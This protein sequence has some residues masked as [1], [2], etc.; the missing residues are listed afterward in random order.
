MPATNV[1][2]QIARAR[3]IVV[4]IGTS[5]ITG[6]DGR[7]DGQVISDLAAQIAA[8]VQAGRSVTL[9]ASGAIGAGMAE[10]DLPQRPKRLP[11]LQATAAVGQGQ[12]MREFHDVFARHGLKVAQVLVTRDAFE[13]RGRY[14]N[15]RQTL[16]AL[17][18]LGVLAIINE[19]DAVAVDEIRFG[20]NDIIAAHVANLI[21]ANLL[22]LLTDVDGVLDGTGVRDVI[23]QVDERAMSLATRGRSR[24]GSGGMV[25]KIAA[26][27]MVTSAGEIAVIANSRQPKVLA[28]LLSGQNVGTAFVPARRRM[29][30]RRRWIAQAARAAGK[31]MIDDGACAAIRQR[32]KSLL[33]SG[34][35]G[36]MGRFA[37]G[38][39]VEVIDRAGNTVARGLCNY[40][41]D[42]IDKIKGMKT[43]QVVGILGPKARDEVVHRNNLTLA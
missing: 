11:M 37:R 32:G 18:G 28:G 31:I 14:L 6:A 40:S 5:A 22:V 10:L 20:D 41:S 35:V 9:V 24:L 39:T 27:G 3:R 7:L 15:I 2:Q 13:D 42:Q 4:K 16:T 36:V 19:N 1:R 23:E 8:M 29:S 25:S 17:A 34:I 33:P 12:L 43:A 30:S 26:A 21:G 38:A